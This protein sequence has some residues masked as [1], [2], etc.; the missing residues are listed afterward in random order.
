[1]LRILVASN[2]S[3][4]GSQSHSLDA[5]HN[6]LF[7]VLVRVLS[8]ASKNQTEEFQPVCFPQDKVEKKTADG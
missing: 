7:A 4:R 5:A 1:M 3:R 6:S 2:C 8:A